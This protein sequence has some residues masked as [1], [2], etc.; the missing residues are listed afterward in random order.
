MEGLG[1][2]FP[3]KGFCSLPLLLPIQSRGDEPVGHGSTASASMSSH[4]ERWSRARRGPGVRRTDMFG[5]LIFS[6][7]S[8]TVKGGER[9][10]RFSTFA[11]LPALGAGQPALGYTA[12][13]THIDH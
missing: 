2:V 5:S 10:M 3:E 13:F 1:K 6:A 8:E 4:A 7:N 12:L 9:V 11:Q